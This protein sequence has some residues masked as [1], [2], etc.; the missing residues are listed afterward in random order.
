[1]RTCRDGDPPP[2]GQKATLPWAGPFAAVRAGLALGARTELCGRFE[3][4][5]ASLAAEALV[6]GEP[7]L[8]IEREWLGFGLGVGF[9]FDG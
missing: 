7:E 9:L 4:G 6:N 3:A 8:V 2:L 5:F 1:M